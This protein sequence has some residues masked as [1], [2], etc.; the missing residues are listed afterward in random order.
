MI[1][2]KEYD[3][4]IKTLKSLK[5]YIKRWQRRKEIISQTNHFDNTYMKGTGDFNSLLMHVYHQ[6]GIIY[7]YV[8]MNRSA[9]DYFKKQLI[10]AWQKNDLFNELQAYYG[11]AM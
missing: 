2:L 3:K 6:I 10:F 8:G 9:M 4:A 7:R 5:N 11:I 1:E